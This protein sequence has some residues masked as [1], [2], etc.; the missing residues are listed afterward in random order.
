MVSE[1]EQQ[2]SDVLKKLPTVHTG[3]RGGQQT[4]RLCT[5]ILNT[6][7]LICLGQEFGDSS[8]RYVLW[9][10]SSMHCIEK[11][12]KATYCRANVWV[13]IN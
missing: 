8:L 5:A 9:L 6:A 4:N 13:E 11:K 10:G 7:H 1:R 3:G 2:A 12:L